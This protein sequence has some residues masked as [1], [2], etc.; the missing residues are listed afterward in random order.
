MKIIHTSMSLATLTLLVG[1]AL[2][3]CDDRRAPE[4][5]TSA[6]A[7][8]SNTV[9]P[10]AKPDNTAVNERD[11]DTSRPTPVNQSESAED[12]RITA[13]I[14]KAVLSISG[15][16]VNGQNVK[17]I[18]AGG[19]VTLRGP[20]ASDSERTAIE[21][22]AKAVAGVTAVVNELETQRL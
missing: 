19:R 17:I 13:E 14:R 1:P 21:D 22:K 4:S 5:T 15:L 12:I 9:T 11:R 8:R 10:P 2:S 18:T 7:A 16:S 6:D 3:G 20:V